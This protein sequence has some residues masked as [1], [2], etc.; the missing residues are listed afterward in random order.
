MHTVVKFGAHFSLAASLK[1]AHVSLLSQI[2]MKILENLMWGSEVVE[3]LSNSFCKFLLRTPLMR[4]MIGSSVP[5][6]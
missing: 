4:A 3:K 2:M 6:K 1:L 5:E